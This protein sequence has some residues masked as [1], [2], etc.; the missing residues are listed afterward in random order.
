MDF[1]FPTK[2]IFITNGYSTAHP[3]IDI[4]WANEFGG[5][6]CPIYAAGDGT[7]SDTADGYNT[8]H[9]KGYGNYIRIE[10]GNG[11]STIY[12]HLLKGSLRVKKGS[13]VKRGQQ[14]AQMGASGNAYGCHIH[15][16]YLINN[17]RK[18]P[19]LYVK[20]E[21]SWQVIYPPTDSKYKIQRLIVNPAD[22]YVVAEDKSRNQLHV[23]ANDL[24]AR[25]APSLSGEVYG[26]MPKGFYNAVT[27]TEADGYRWVKIAD[28][29]YAAVVTGYS[30]YAPAEDRRDEKIKELTAT[31][32]NIEDLAAAAIK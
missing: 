28:D 29:L 11:I 25:K 20:A 1:T 2:F 31:L 19:L 12:A 3:A 23:T 18:N 27:L 32:V 30:E 15:F 4:G 8:D 22:K 6:N 5:C 14:I 13:A 16:C 26:W 21:E 10:H 7:V 17:V 9:T 24:R